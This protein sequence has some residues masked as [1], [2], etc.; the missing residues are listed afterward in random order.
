MKAFFSSRSTRNSSTDSGL[1][2]YSLPPFPHPLPEGKLTIHITKDDLIIL[3]ATSNHHHHSQDSK[4]NRLNIA[5]QSNTKPSI[6]INAAN[7]AA[8]VKWGKE[9]VVQSINKNQLSQALQSHESNFDLVCYGIVG[10]VK[11]FNCESQREG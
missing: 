4:D 11:L 3:P 1:S 5:T 8:R 10:I 9:G 6:N 7:S 2:N